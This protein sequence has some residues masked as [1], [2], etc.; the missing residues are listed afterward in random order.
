[1]VPCSRSRRR[2]APVRTIA[3]IVML[4]MSCMTP[5]YQDSYRFGLNF[6]RTAVWIGRGDASPPPPE[7]YSRSS[8]PRIRSRYAAPIPAWL[9]AV[10]S[11]LICKSGC[12]PAR[13]SAS[14]SGGMS[15]TKVNR[16]ESR[17]TS[18]SSTERLSGAR[19]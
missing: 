19:K 7:T 6:T 4:L 10:A 13:T 15:R 1:M 11:T 8:A 18:I 5:R 16:P 12:L 3:S 14:K 2:A 17:A 9:M